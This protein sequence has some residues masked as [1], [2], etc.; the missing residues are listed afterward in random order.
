MAE[1]VVINNTTY[2]GV[3]ALAL[4]RSDGS[5]ASFYPDA[6]RYVE[7]TLTEAQKAQARAN[8]NAVSDLYT[9]GRK[10]IC[11]K[12]S[13]IIMMGDSIMDGYGGSD[14]N[15]AAGDA[16][17][18]V[19]TNTAGYCFANVFKKFAE[20][21]FGIPVENKGQYGSRASKQVS[22]AQ[23]YLTGNELVIWLTGTNNRI[24]ESDYND[25]VQNFAQYVT[26]IE[27]VCADLLILSCTPTLANDETARYKTTQDICNV[28]ISN[29]GGSNFLDMRTLYADFCEQRSIEIASTLADN[30]HPNDLG[31]WI[32]FKLLC[33]NIGLALSTYTNYKYDGGWWVVPTAYTN[34]VP[35]AINTDGSI[36][37]NG[38]GYQND[39]RMNS[40]GG[41]AQLEGACHT[42]YIEIVP[43]D[44]VRSYGSDNIGA[45][46]GY[47]AW[48]DASFANIHI[49][50]G[51]TG[52]N[53]TAEQQADGKYLVTWD[54]SGLPENTKY[55]RFSFN[56]CQGENLIITRNEEIT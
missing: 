31:H 27:S 4:V 53:L 36:Y 49:F 43:G 24:S 6:V 32:L 1:N 54:T 9:I 39:Y 46:G 23:K 25:Y 33:Q 38:L 55:V 3:D 8:I 28:I 14:Y 42:G 17:Y 56:K 47:L 51:H 19:S 52:T 2:N 45:S 18:E 15:G 34:L 44:I 30:V 7:Q 11:G 50:N 22:E 5:V 26:T 10:I 41:T 40:S 16:L 20:E 21:R 12:Y 13:K 35:T 29:V 48:Y 37:N